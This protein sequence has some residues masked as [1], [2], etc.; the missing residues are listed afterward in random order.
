MINFLVIM[1][2]ITIIFSLIV[3][4]YLFWK[5][6]TTHKWN[7]LLTKKQT[8]SN[9][10]ELQQV[11]HRP[12][13]AFMSAVIIFLFVAVSSPI[14]I[15]ESINTLQFGM[16]MNDSVDRD[17]L[18]ADEHIDYLMNSAYDQMKNEDI[19]IVQ[20]DSYGAIDE[21]NILYN[22]VN[23]ELVDYVNYD[24]RLLEQVYSR[25]SDTLEIDEFSDSALNLK[26]TSETAA[27]TYNVSYSSLQI[28]TSSTSLEYNEV[29]LIVGGYYTEEEANQFTD[30]RLRG[31]DYLYTWEA[32]LLE[33]YDVTKSLENQNNKIKLILEEYTKHVLD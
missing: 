5:T 10:V 22:K 18:T 8:E 4:I 31:E 12:R 30:Y 13:Y 27:F 32:I 14:A 17:I 28:G 24:V 20:I 19:M 23:D 25:T 3:I 6:Y 16:M 2:K 9:I 29:Y 26:V 33:G 11:N 7:R 15:I 1:L 21:Y